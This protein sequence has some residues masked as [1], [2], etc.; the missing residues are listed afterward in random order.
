MNYLKRKIQRNT[1]SVQLEIYR[2]SLLAKHPPGNDHL[3]FHGQNK[4]EVI[5]NE[6]FVFVAALA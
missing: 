5:E 2:K 6:R 4:N 1:F 3:T